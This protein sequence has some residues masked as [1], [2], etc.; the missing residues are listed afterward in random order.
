MLKTFGG[1]CIFHTIVWRYF[2]RHI[3][4]RRHG[5]FSRFHSLWFTLKERQQFHK[6]ST[7]KGRRLQRFYEFRANS[8]RA[9]MSTLRRY[10]AELTLISQKTLFTK[11]N[12]GFF[13]R[14]FSIYSRNNSHRRRLNNKRD[15]GSY[16]FYCGYLSYFRFMGRFRSI[17]R[18]KLGL[19]ALIG[20]F[21]GHTLTTDVFSLIN[22]KN[23]H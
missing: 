1:F 3:S 21:S 5:L 12:L 14:I 17:T 20:E 10:F 9:N 18:Y 13:Q 11:M 8:K 16:V 22:G 19:K 4:C 6:A 2:F 7:E 23:K 15:Y